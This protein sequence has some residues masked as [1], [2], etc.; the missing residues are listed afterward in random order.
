MVSKTRCRG[1]TKGG[2]RCLAPV[3]TDREFCYFHDPD[4]EAEAAEARRLGGLRRKRESTLQ[5][6]YEITGVSTLDDLL[7]LLEVVTFDAL[8]LDNSVARGRLLLGVVQTGTKLI[9]VGEHEERLAAIE[10]A[11]GPRLVKKGRR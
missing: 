10:A 8:S 11:L 3:L 6:A 2:E 5:G 4:H 9:E 1:I 7:R